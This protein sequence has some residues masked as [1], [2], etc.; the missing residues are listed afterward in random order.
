M[1]GLAGS[2]AR[3]ASLFLADENSA[4]PLGRELQ[5]LIGL[6]GDSP[7]TAAAA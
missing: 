2:I 3:R 1:E 7:R 4:A 6:F 5:R